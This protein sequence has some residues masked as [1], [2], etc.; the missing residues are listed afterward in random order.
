MRHAI[1]MQRHAQVAMICALA[2]FMTIV[3]QAMPGD[4]DLT[5]GTAGKAVT[6]TG[7]WNYLNA[8][9]IQPDGKIVIVGNSLTTGDTFAV[10]RY[11]RDGA[12]DTTFDGEVVRAGY[13]RR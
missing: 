9:A 1:R 8:L 2:L 10:L 7:S 11:N 13:P 12:L 5:F 6:N 3:G 4:I